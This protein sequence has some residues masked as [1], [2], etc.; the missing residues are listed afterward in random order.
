MCSKGREGRESPNTS[1]ASPLKGRAPQMIFILK[2]CH[3]LVLTSLTNGHVFFGIVRNGCVLSSWWCQTNQGERAVSTLVTFQGP[4]GIN[5]NHLWGHLHW[6]AT[7]CTKAKPPGADKS[8]PTALSPPRE[9]QATYRGIAAISNRSASY[10]MSR[11]HPLIHKWGRL[12]K[13]RSW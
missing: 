12:L 2:W 6:G 8:P 9:R 5:I 13:Q 1:T 10:L 11:R 4:R 3:T 7:S